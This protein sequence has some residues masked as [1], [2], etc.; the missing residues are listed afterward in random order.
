MELTQNNLQAQIDP[1][2]FTKPYFS[3]VASTY[4]KITAIISGIV[5]LLLN[6][7]RLS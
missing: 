5:I 4:F 7:A 2:T 3:I 1:V 6:F